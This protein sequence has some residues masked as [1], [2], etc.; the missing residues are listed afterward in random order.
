MIYLANGTVL[1]S[2]T[3]LQILLR[4]H[5]P[6]SLNKTDGHF[7]PKTKK[8]VEDFQVFHAPS[9]V[10]DGIVGRFTW[11]KLMGVSRLQTIDVVDGD[12]PSLVNLEAADIRNAGGNPI[13]VYGMSNGVEVV[14]NEI[15]NRAQGPGRVALLRFHGHGGRGSQNVSGG[16][17]N[18]APHLAAISDD[19][20]SQIR[21]KLQ[22]ISHIFA[23]FGS[24]QLLG[25]DVGGGAKGKSLISKLANVWGVPVTAGLHTQFGG[26]K[27][28]FTFEGPTVT[29]FPAGLNDLKS[30][31]KAMEDAHGNVSVVDAA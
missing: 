5:S 25:C 7:G 13:V 19:N 18:G 30:W 16:H 15:L 24:T 6:H 22:R 17:I 26:G 2:V 29:G 31:S 12:D 10:K 8:A 20:F 27:Q 4:R 1:P 11:T 14:M 21:G 28:T 23:P 3:T 9:L